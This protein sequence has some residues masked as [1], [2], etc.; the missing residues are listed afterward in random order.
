[1]VDNYL[2]WMSITVTSLSYIRQYEWHTSGK[3]G[4]ALQ[5]LLLAERRFSV[6]SV[7]R[8]EIC[9]QD[10]FASLWTGVTPRSSFFLFLSLT[11]FYRS[12]ISLSLWLNLISL[13]LLF[14]SVLTYRKSFHLSSSLHF[15]FLFSFFFLCL[16]LDFNGFLFRLIF[17]RRLLSFQFSFNF[18]FFFLLVTVSWLF[19]FLLFFFVLKL[20]SRGLT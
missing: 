13:L 15:R 16:P 1:M 19:S 5:H 9:V 2:K 8:F 4:K 17:S 7:Y 20:L 3:G 6:L 11:S 18:F 10:A 14:I 12:L